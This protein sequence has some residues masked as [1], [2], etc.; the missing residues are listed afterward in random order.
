M[1][2]NKNIPVKKIIKNTK[3]D[4]NCFK[5]AQ[6]YSANIDFNGKYATIK[7]PKIEL[8]KYLALDKDI[9][10]INVIPMNGS[11]QVVKDTALTCIPAIDLSRV[12]QF[13]K[14]NV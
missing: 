2:V 11:I 6:I 5:D 12:E 3:V 4:I 13:F 14:P 9:K 8:I 1:K 7:L 10:T